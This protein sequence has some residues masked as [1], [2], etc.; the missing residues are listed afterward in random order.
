MKEKIWNH[1]LAYN[2]WIKKKVE[3]KKYILD[4]GCGKGYLDFE[5]Y[6]DTRFITGIDIDISNNNYDNN[7]YPNLTFIKDDFIEYDFKNKKY[8]AIV[9]V[10]SIHHMNMEIA[11]EKAKHLL[12]KEG[13][14]LI[15]GISK[16]TN[17]IDWSI[18]IGRIIPCKI[19]SSLKKMRTCEDLNI[20]VNYRYDSLSN[21]KKVFKRII[22]N[23]K[24]KYGLYYR[25]LLYWK[26]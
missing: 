7:K 22:P 9:F 13:V 26:K 14:I 23:Y 17:I 6:N 20:K 11:L 3:G 24:L 12:N 10:A 4:V 2:N 19:I 18:D 25:Y 1:N 21:I 8:D 5:L 16:P 15:V